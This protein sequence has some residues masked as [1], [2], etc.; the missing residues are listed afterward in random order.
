MGGKA[1]FGGGASAAVGATVVQN[2]GATTEQANPTCTFGASDTTGNDIIATGFSTNGSASVPTMTGATFV[3]QTVSGGVGSCTLGPRVQYYWLAHNVTGGQTVITWSDGAS[4]N[5]I[6]AIEVHGLA[7][8]NDGNY[9]CNNNS[10]GTSSSPVTSGTTGTPS[11]SNEFA[12]TAMRVN[13]AN[14]WTSCTPY[15]IIRNTGNSYLMAS[16]I[17]STATQSS[18]AYTGSNGTFNSAVQLFK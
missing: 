15:T 16:N 6:M 5:F 11:Q 1:G 3:Q 8:G 18:C 4:T 13:A 10:L 9:F 7:T 2:C 12:F 17:V 14:T